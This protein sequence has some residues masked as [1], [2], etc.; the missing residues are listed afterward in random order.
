MIG[1]QLG[2][3]QIIEQVGA[4]DPRQLMEQIR[5]RMQQ[6]LENVRLSLEA[7]KAVLTK[8]QWDRLPERLRNLGNQPRQGG[9]RRPGGDV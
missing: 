8:E 4:G 3:Y 7:V 6:A 9:V 5:P 1:S 2:P